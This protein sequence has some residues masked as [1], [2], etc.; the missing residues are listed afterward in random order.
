MSI[1]K[2]SQDLAVIQ[3][4]SDLPN[5]ADGLTA[6]QLKAKFDESGLEIQKWINDVLLPGLKAENLGFAGN[7]EVEA[8]N[9]QAAIELVHRQ[10]R[11]ASAG[12][13]ANGTVSKEKLAAALLERVFGGRV[14][15]SLDTPTEEH[16]PENDFPI[17]QLWLRP[18][19]RVENLVGENWSA[20]GCTAVQ[21]GQ[22]LQI[23][24]NQTVASVYAVQQL[25]GIGQ[26][27][28][29]V[30]V[31]LDVEAK[32]KE[33][34]ALT[35]SLNEAAAAELN[36]DIRE[37]TL[38]AGGALKIR[39]DALWPA[40]SLAAGTIKLKH[41]TVINPDA[42][43]R[44]TAGARDLRDWKAWLRAKV[45]FAAM[46]SSREMYVQT[47]PGVWQLFD[48]EVLAVSHGGTGVSSIGDG[49]MLFGKDGGFAKLEKPQN[50]TFLQFDNGN[51]AWAAMGA[52]AGH[53]FARILC[54]SYEGN[55]EERTINLPVEPKLLVIHEGKNAAV[56]QDGTY[57]EQSLSASYIDSMTSG[58]Y[59]AGVQLNGNKL[60]TY[61]KGYEA[62]QN[63]Q[64]KAWNQN[65][66]T[67]HWVAIY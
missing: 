27:G 42:V 23:T 4:L 15:V 21:S 17:G 39:I 19:F 13:I 44:E 55:A 57:Q 25:T 47:A 14:W 37:A 61:M 3:K 33:L 12:S 66:D 67:Y 31:V 43:L 45:P 34:I 16:T 8:E 65:S 63:P 53:G 1:E 50:G 64:P 7:S 48:Q 10:I 56:L 46:E 6:E 22:S 2:M 52:L 62:F 30:L 54:G 9:V 58:T 29:R 18:A 11:D 59:T 51:P 24:G 32:D 5:S 20:T 60:T 38:Q 49:E 35:V 26:A 36:G 28:D 41:V 40:T